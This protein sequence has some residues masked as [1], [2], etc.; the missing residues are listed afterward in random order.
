MSAKALDFDPIQQIFKARDEKNAREA[1][2][3]RSEG[4][5][6]GADARRRPSRSTSRPRSSSV[7]GKRLETSQRKPSQ[8]RTR[9]EDMPEQDE[10]R[11]Q[12]RTSETGK[13]AQRT[14]QRTTQ[15]AS[16][17][18]PQTGYKPRHAKSE[19]ASKTNIKKA[20][21]VAGV[22]AGLLMLINALL[23]SAPA[24][25]VR[26]NEAQKADGSIKPIHYNVNQNDDG[27]TFIITDSARS[28]QYDADANTVI[29][30]DTTGETD[31][32]TD[33][34]TEEPVAEEPEE[35]PYVP[36]EHVSDNMIN[37]MKGFE[38][39]HLEA[40]KCPGGAW[41]IGFGH[42]ADVYEGQTITQEEANNLFR[43][44]LASF[45]KK[46]RDYAASLGVELTQ[47][48]FDALVDFAY[49]LGKGAFEN[50]GLVE[51]IGEGDLDGAAAHMQE[52]V[53]AKNE[54]GEKVKLA[55]LVTRRAT[56]AEWLYT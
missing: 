43:Q 41:T 10:F 49:N 27:D 47:G 28:V 8:G 6:T 22:G 42:T 26:N 14:T 36:I 24:A 17:R 16:Q 55:G 7:G 20:G 37:A 45:E 44:D 18:R 5:A 39:C 34:V 56:E 46:V 52:Y 1:A 9:L 3:R 4:K 38:G 31:E 48:Q 30:Y 21:S 12:R 19:G 51:M 13:P 11:P 2:Q 23:P 32:T 53:Y 50:S 35:A 15:A 25:D 33:V 29:I 40:Y 54:D